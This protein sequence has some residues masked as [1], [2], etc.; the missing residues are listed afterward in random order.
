[1]LCLR[2]YKPC[3]AEKIVSWCADETAF[4]L[5]SAGRFDHYPITAQEF[6]AYYDAFA[7]DEDFFALCAYD[8]NGL[9]G[10][11]LLRALDSAKRDIRFGMI[12]VDPARRG[13]GTGYAML[14]RALAY[15]FSFLQAQ[16]VTLGV[17][18][19]NAAARR[20]YERLGFG[21]LDVP[22]D[23]LQVGESVWRLI[24]VGMTRAMWEAKMTAEETK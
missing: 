19:Q 2:P 13:Q 16:R 18:E 22:G 11:V 23:T 9:A 17:F 6:N 14:S 12:I 7:Q 21:A 4:Y 8:E 15:A 10:Q 3:D 1:M 20:C 24:E 5:W